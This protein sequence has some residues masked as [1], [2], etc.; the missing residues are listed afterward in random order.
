MEQKQ[1]RPLLYSLSAVFLILLC[2]GSGYIL[3]SPRSDAAGSP[4]PVP[5]LV[6]SLSET[7]DTIMPAL[8]EEFT[9]TLSFTGDNLLSTEY[10]QDYSWSFLETAKSQPPEYFYENVSHIFE[11]SDFTIANCENVFSDRDLTPVTKT[12]SPAFWF[13][14]PSDI[15]NIFTTAN[16]D[17]VTIANNHANDFGPEGY[18][19][20]KQALDNAGVLWCSNEQIAYVEKNG[21][22][23]AVLG[24]DM[25]SLSYVDGIKTLL[26]EAG[27]QSDFQI[28][29]FHGGTEGSYEV[30]DWKRDACHQLIDHGAD[31]IIGAHPHRIQKI[32]T[33]NDVNIVY[34]LGNFLF[35]GNKQP[36]KESMIYR[37]I[38][39]IRDGQL[40]ETQSTVIP[41]HSYSGEQNN[42]QPCVLP[43]GDAKDRILE[44][45][46]GERELPY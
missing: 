45:V 6:F 11:A 44:F 18:A 22:R 17:V 8:P 34:S 20:T 39:T 16:I 2:I 37:E 41:C 10:Y 33:Y 42:W 26:T 24:V 38:L 46:A 13:K 3:Y 30:E 19:D 7:G 25:W 31:L 28:V 14:S 9:I 12:S 15:A 21:F 1:K 29:Y 35:G 40:Q 23:I 5:A 32:E 36:V 27:A 43:D 4:Q